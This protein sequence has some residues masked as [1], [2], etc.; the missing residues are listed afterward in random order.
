MQN[1]PQR[2]EMFF[3]FLDDIKVEIK[4]FNDH[5]FLILNESKKIIQL[6][7]NNNSGLNFENIQN[8]ISEKFLTFI[9]LLTVEERNFYQPSKKDK[10]N[11]I[12]DFVA[13]KT[14]S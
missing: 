4:I 7:S 5:K 3:S 12:R 11:L 10:I 2:R 14:P 13:K 9:D 1:I 8:Y 6:N